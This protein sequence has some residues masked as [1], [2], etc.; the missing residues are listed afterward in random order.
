MLLGKMLA[1]LD[2]YGWEGVLCTLHTVCVCVCV[3]VC[4]GVWVVCVCVC[5]W[6]VYVRVGG[7][8][9]CVFVCVDLRD[10]PVFQCCCFCYC[11]CGHMQCINCIHWS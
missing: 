10:V 9:M 8:C 11:V 6:C 1:V 5:G 4:V 2:F 3:C 7:V